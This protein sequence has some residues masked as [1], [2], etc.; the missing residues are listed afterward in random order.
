MLVLWG[1][2]EYSNSSPTRLKISEE[3]IENY[4]STYGVQ[5]S[6]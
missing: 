1:Y 5:E 3:E 2:A 6:F 4:R